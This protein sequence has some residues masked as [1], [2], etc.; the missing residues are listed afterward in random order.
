[1]QRSMRKEAANGDAQPNGAPQNLQLD[2]VVIGAGFAGVYLLHRLRNEGFNVK[3]VEAGTGLGGIWY[4]NS[5][6]F[7][8][9]SGFRRTLIVIK[10]TPVRE[11]TLP[12]R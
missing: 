8:P 12:T 9:V 7:Q 6:L 5:M 4:W 10:T 11:L 2:A 3:L 1:M